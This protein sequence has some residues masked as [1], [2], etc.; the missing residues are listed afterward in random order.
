VGRNVN[1]IGCNNVVVNADVDNFEA[2]GC[3]DQVFDSE[4]S[5]KTNIRNG[6]LVVSE[7]SINSTVPFTTPVNW[8]AKII[9]FSTDADTNVYL[10]NTTS[11]SIAATL[12][13]YGI[14]HTF[15]KTSASN[16]LTLTPTS[17]QIDFLASL[18]VTDKVTVM[19]DG[20]NWW[21]I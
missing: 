6:A 10:C 21:T 11:G 2:I 13:N 15:K 12:D 5:D 9:N 18:V 14:A 4:S 8:A 1:L 7:T 3:S 16:T 17:G 20:S 19:F